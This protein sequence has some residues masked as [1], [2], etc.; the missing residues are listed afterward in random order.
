ML[1]SDLLLTVHNRSNSD[2]VMNG[3]TYFM[4]LNSYILWLISTPISFMMLEVIL[5]DMIYVSA[6]G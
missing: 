1:T 4:A 6:I 3:N 2:T 5:V